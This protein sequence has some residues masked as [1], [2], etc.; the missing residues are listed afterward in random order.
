MTG[1]PASATIRILDPA[2]VIKI[3]AGEVV[4]RPASVVKELVENAVDAGATAIRIE[5]VSALG[6]VRSIRV[7]DN[8]CGMSGEDAL[9]AFAPHA[10]SKIRDAS[11]LEAIGTLGFRG[12][13]LASIAAIA[14]V[15]LTTRIR[16]GGSLAGTRVV[17][18]GGEVRENHEAGAPEG[19]SVLVEN[20]FFNTPARRKFLKTLH[21]EIAH[22]TEVIEGVALARPAIRISLSHNGKD[23]VTTGPAQR[24]MDTVAR[25][26]GPDVA[27]SLIPVHYTSPLVT[28]IGFVSLP[29]VLR[30]NPRR[31]IVAINGRYVSSLTVSNAIIEGYGTLL[32]KDRYPVAYLSLAIDSRLVD[33]NVHPS[34]KLVRLSREGQVRD[35]VRDAV[36]TA[37]RGADLVPAATV[38][39]RPDTGIP[40]TPPF[41]PGRYRHDAAFGSFVSEPTHAGTLATDRQLRQT[42][43]STGAG[44][45]QDRLPQMELVGQFGSIYLL[46]A[47]SG[48]DLVIIDQH[49]AHERIMY[50]LIC[51]KNA[52]APLSQELIVPVIIE[53][54]A[55]DAAVIKSLLP[56]LEEEGFSISEFGRNSF[57]VSAI[58]VILG[59]IEDAVSLIT[60]IADDLTREDLKNT[61]TRR[62][63]VTRII[64]CRGAIKAGT[65]CTGEQ[66][67]RLIQ[68]LSRTKDPFTC[69]HGRPTLIRF[70]RGQLDT[71]FRRTVA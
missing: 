7:T 55:R 69:P 65:V 68:Q 60:D 27:G 28:I 26:F 37:L 19:T 13:A 43:L 52:S 8:G 58:P 29:Q 67:K 54:S 24:L 44:P 53:R 22:I 48:G 42:E 45:E 11:D 21:T 20:L 71:L 70:S 30:K 47:T 31:I 62:E 46:A 3:A 66:C 34:K 51:A 49:A 23:L 15:T 1:E 5:V 35:I 40:A 6:S 38:Q 33:V 18:E 14:R 50:D 10:T 57:M 12:E 63:Q 41:P 25:I 17:I 32:P 39:A 64:A 2:T 59:K 61:V 4:E 9:L 16:G 36:R 56:L